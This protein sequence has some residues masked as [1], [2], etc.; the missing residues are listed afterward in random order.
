MLEYE[1]TTLSADHGAFQGATRVACF[2]RSNSASALSTVVHLRQ[3]SPRAHPD[4]PESTIRATVSIDGVR[5]G[6]AVQ[7]A[8]HYHPSQ[9]F[10]YGPNP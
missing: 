9:E 1:S 2:T 8:T 7:T 5:R 3:H 4:D 6:G 10:D